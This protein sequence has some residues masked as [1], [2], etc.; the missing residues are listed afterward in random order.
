MARQPDQGPEQGIDWSETL[1][2]SVDDA[3]NRA[4]PRGRDVDFAI[5]QNDMR[6]DNLRQSPPDTSDKKEFIRR[7]NAKIEARSKSRPE[8]ARDNQ[9]G[10]GKDE[11]KKN[12]VIL[13]PVAP[14]EKLKA[15]VNQ[16]KAAQKQQPEKQP[17]KQIAQ[18]EQK[19]AQETTKVVESV[20]QESTKEMSAEVDKALAAHAISPEHAQQAKA[21]INNEQVK[22]G[23]FS[24]AFGAVKDKAVGVK[25][26]FADSP[27]LTSL[28]VGA[29]T[30]MGVRYAVKA[31]FIAAFG[32]NLPWLVAAGAT[33]GGLLEGGRSFWRE[34]KSYQSKEIMDRF[35]GADYLEKAAMLS[36]L[37]EAYKTQ[38]FD[39]SPEGYQEIGTALAHAR[40]EMQLE[41]DKKDGKL[42]NHS[43][44]DKIQYILNL[45][46]GIK[47][48]IH[49]DNRGKEARKLIRDIEKSLEYKRDFKGVLQNKKMV[50]A[51]AALKG[52]AYGG[53][54]SLIGGAVSNYFFESGTT[55][56]VSHVVE[57]RPTVSDQFTKHLDHRGLTG[58]AR[59]SLHD[60]IE[61]QR[62]IDPNFAEGVTV[63]QLVYAEDTLA[64]EALKNGVKSGVSE[65]TWTHDE[66]MRAL[67]KSGAV[68]DSSTLTPSG[69]RN[70]E[71]LISHRPH[72]LSDATREKMLDFTPKDFSVVVE[73]ITSQPENIV[74]SNEDYAA[75]IG[76]LT[77]VAASE[78]ASAADRRIAKN[79]LE[80]MQAN[81]P[82]GQPGTGTEA[83]PPNNVVWPTEGVLTAEEARV[84]NKKFPNGPPA[85]PFDGNVETTPIPKPEGSPFD[86]A[87]KQNPESAPN[88]VDKVGKVVEIEED[89]ENVEAQADV[90]D[91]P[92]VEII[93]DSEVTPDAI[94]RKLKS[95]KVNAEV[96][97]WPLEKIT[98]K[99]KGQINRLT[100]LY[101]SSARKLNALNITNKVVLNFYPSGSRELDFKD[102]E[103]TAGIPLSDKSYNKKSFESLV[104]RM[105]ETKISEKFAEIQNNYAFQT[106]MP[107]VEN[108]SEGQA[109][110]QYKALDKFQRNME[111]ID[112]KDLK[113]LTSGL[114]KVT[115]SD[116]SFIGTDEMVLPMFT[117]DSRGYHYK[118]FKPNQLK[119]MLKEY[120]KD[121]FALK[122]MDLREQNDKYPNI[123]ADKNF[124]DN[125]EDA[126]RNKTE[127]LVYSVIENEFKDGFPANVKVLFSDRFQSK[128]GVLYIDMT[129]FDQ[130]YISRQLH[131]GLRRSAPDRLQRTPGPVKERLNRV[132]PDY[133]KRKVSDQDKA[134]E[135]SVDRIIRPEDWEKKETGPANLDQIQEENDE[136]LLYSLLEDIE[137]KYS[138]KIPDKMQKKITGYLNTN[139]LSVQDL[140]VMN[141]LPKIT[142]VLPNK[143]RQYV[144]EESFAQLEKMINSEEDLTN[145]GVNLKNQLE[146]FIKK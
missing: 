136:E 2:T 4:R 27:R 24:R 138:G 34:S 131:Q 69:E 31:G 78:V 50:V 141:E 33:A 134:I 57:N 117:R 71:R 47:G 92:G 106:E 5:Q 19:A 42:A 20:V 90:Q 56:T 23:V 91:L 9:V 102:S 68:G 137:K 6:E 122:P 88:K 1:K 118:S 96:V 98:N 97:P 74:L 128:P 53:L 59:D 73:Q 146:E 21:V 55:Q 121:R 62:G 28:L 135:A 133:G 87:K 13:Q 37:E 67:E 107:D 40:T 72:F 22:Q 45:S 14:A 46:Q 76:V 129:K 65:H 11:L 95:A 123:G 100:D 77:L 75:I 115:I 120:S 86:D 49:K 81:P 16:E 15:A 104:D 99:Q 60:L 83:G 103:F 48:E 105:I 38:R 142:S 132:S 84:D 94:D 12:E 54:G 30:G 79:R 26:W 39:A 140:L 101:I 144:A 51:K 111:A 89:S 113:R 126:D 143:L 93:K 7:E 139:N 8:K 36:K 116:Y 112:A 64:K 52:A 25:E 125:I 124:Y 66:L 18:Q 32:A 29:G 82:T 85:S 80:Q 43:E 110:E 41:L 61:E 108:S 114:K 145:E 127:E 109:T 3:K 58:G 130:A 10:K 119:G 44:R 17:E 70:I 35:R 63:E